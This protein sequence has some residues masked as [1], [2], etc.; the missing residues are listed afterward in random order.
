MSALSNRVDSANARLCSKTSGKA[1]ITR[2]RISAKSGHF[3]RCA[4]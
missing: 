4:Q 1:D 3:N 2:L